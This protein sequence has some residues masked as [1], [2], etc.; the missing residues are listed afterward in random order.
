MKEKISIQSLKR[1]SIGIEEDFIIT[2]VRKLTK[3][4]PHA[5]MCYIILHLNR[6]QGEVEYKEISH[7]LGIGIINVK[8]ILKILYKHGL[9]NYEEKENKVTI[10][11]YDLPPDEKIFEVEK[12]KKEIFQPKWKEDPINIW[13]ASHFTE[14]WH[15]TYKENIG[16]RYT[17]ITVKEL[18]VFKKMYEEFGRQA[19]KD[20]IYEFIRFYEKYISGPPSVQALYGFRRTVF[21]QFTGGRTGRSDQW[22]EKEVEKFKDKNTKGGR[23]W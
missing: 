18:S 11:I 6:F 19:L 1:S 14:Y 22:K 20:S 21:P 5:A 16:I 12:E 10:Q 4:S 2:W 8:P 9:I 17:K 3:D 13:N 23:V 7:V 15:D